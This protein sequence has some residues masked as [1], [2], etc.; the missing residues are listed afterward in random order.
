MV[1]DFLSENETRYLMQIAQPG[2]RPSKTAKKTSFDVHR[3]SYSVST[4]I[5]HRVNWLVKKSH[6]RS[7]GACSLDPHTA[8][9]ANSVRSGGTQ[10]GLNASLPLL[11]LLLLLLPPLPLPLLLRPQLLSARCSCV[12]H[13]TSVAFH[14]SVCGGGCASAA[15]MATI[16]D[17]GMQ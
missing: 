14:A 17:D 10:L 3:T 15:A 7:A 5:H 8:A 4:E 9:A 13:V 16:G 12:P 6:V 1:D 11:L 2:L